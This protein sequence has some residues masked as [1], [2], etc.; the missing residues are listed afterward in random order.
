MA[1]L[2]KYAPSNTKNGYFLRG[3]SPSSGYYT[4]NT[5]HAANKL[6]DDL[7]YNPGRIPDTEGDSIPGTLTW[8]MYQ[9]GLLITENDSVL[10][11]LTDSELKDTFEDATES[12]SLSDT[13]LKTIQQFIS[14]Y[15]GPDKGIVEKLDSLFATPSKSGNT[16][17]DTDTGTGFPSLDP[18][19][20]EGEKRAKRATKAGTSL[21]EI[22]NHLDTLGDDQSKVIVADAETLT[23]HPGG[24]QSFIDFWNAPSDIQAILDTDAHDTAQYTI[25]HPST[26]HDTQ[27]LIVNDYTIFDSPDNVTNDKTDVFAQQH[28]ATRNPDYILKFRTNYDTQHMVDEN[29]DLYLGDSPTMTHT[30]DVRDNHLQNWIIEIEG[31]HWNADL[32][33]LALD[34]AST[35]LDTLT[36]FFDDF[37]GYTLETPITDYTRFTP[38]FGVEELTDDEKEKIRIIRRKTSST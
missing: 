36:T 33:L 21:E 14:S 18:R 5:T 38:V 19:D 12:L 34:Q 23:S 35:H 16:D 10:D 25:E 15:T 26:H 1:N 7:N 4:L 8:R 6:F 29:F 24:A 9:V 27:K 20:H 17:T 13:D 28:K 22:Q 37:D 2:Y 31:H 32:Q 3:R 30:I 11:E